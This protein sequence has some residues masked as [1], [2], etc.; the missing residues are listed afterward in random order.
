MNFGRVKI[1]FPRVSR[2]SKID[3]LI[4]QYA[5]IFKQSDKQYFNVLIDFTHVKEI[6]LLQVLVYYKFVDYSFVNDKL[7]L[8]R[9]NESKVV[10]EAIYRFGFQEFFI[11]YM[12]LG[13]DEKI[14]NNLKVKEVDGFL[15]APQGL[16]RNISITKNSLQEKFLP[17][18]QAYYKNNDSGISLLFT[19][20]SE[21]ALNF[22]EHATDDNASVIMAYGSKAKIEIACV[23]N[24][25]GIISTL[26]SSVLRSANG[27]T[28]IKKAMEKGVTS[29]KRTNHMGY[30]LWLISEI[31][32]ATNGI[33][34][35][36]SEGFCYKVERRKVSIGKSGYWKGTIFY[37]SLP[38]ET[39]LGL[40]DIV[41]STEKNDGNEPAINWQ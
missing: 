41:G 22:W 24:G 28:I 5:F 8:P 2:A 13:A 26:R 37:L 3:D 40:V 7:L 9:Y 39:G 32:K 15:I 38:L 30:G 34:Y 33:M 14:Y 17:E 19:C 6:S 36:Y 11:S 4:K 10:N 29:K 20:L 12:E 21:V 25:Q 31:A 16:L 23:D 18:I 27:E 1:V 35:V